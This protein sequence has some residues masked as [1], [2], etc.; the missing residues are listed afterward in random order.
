M[1]ASDYFHSWEDAYLGFLSATLF[2]L[3]RRGEVAS[4]T[5][6][7]TIEIPIKEP[8]RTKRRCRYAG[9]G[10]RAREGTRTC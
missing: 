1:C 7:R 9:V 3:D 2:S 6:P 5:A 10:I 8:M 4:S